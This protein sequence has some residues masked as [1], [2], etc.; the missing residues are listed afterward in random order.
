[1]IEKLAQLHPEMAL[2]ATVCVVMVIGLLRSN[3]WRAACA[4]VTGAG[5]LVAMILSLRSPVT[6]GLLPQFLPYTKTLIAAIGLL[7]LPLMGGTVDRWYEGQ[8]GRGV[9]FDPI[10]V[11]RGEFYAFYLLSFMGAM[12]CAT[13]DDLIWLFLALELT[14]LP[15]YVM[16]AMS[17]P[18]LRSQ[19]AGVKYFF[20][21]AL[22]AAT[23]LYGF[24]ML[25]GAT[26]STHLEDIAIHLRTNGLGVLSTLGLVM[27]FVGISFKIA[28]VPMHFYTPDVYQGAASPV[29]AFLAFVPKASGF[30]VL[31]QLLATVG[32]GWGEHG[33]SLPDALRIPLWVI[34]ALTMTFGNVLAM[35]QSNAK[36]MLA[37]SSIAHSGYMLV[38]LIVG[39]GKS[40]ATNGLAAAMF[41]LLCYGVMN[42]GAFAVLACLDKRNA[43]GEV[44]E[45]ETLDDL[46]GLYAARPWLAI[47]MML[48]A[49]SLLGMP[50]LLGF[51]G[52]L[53]LFTSGISAGEIGL[54]IV[55]AL[56]SA[57]A[58][59]YYL[60]L[61]R[62]AILDKRNEDFDRPALTDVFGRRLA[63]AL[64]AA[65]VLVVVIWASPLQTASDRATQLN[66]RIRQFNENVIETIGEVELTEPQT[67]AALSESK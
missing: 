53:M 41:Y 58:A 63:A 50:P 45:I 42:L 14:S 43:D 57:A 39:P 59:F 21:G 1:M 11:T 26:G 6:E 47:A 48:C 35:L 33:G 15:T 36:R 66:P 44:V 65:G 37:Y 20:L 4:W 60:R 61:V 7:V 28:A 52:K 38:G 34:A 5:L 31:I 67:V 62:A 56:N 55:M 17:T 13:A 18:R 2:F 49:L 64:S 9:A 30:I 23:F 16:V 22:S 27:A 51:W 25:Y 29:S 54:V 19:E 24:V 3:F 8:V 46:R 12:L 32:W 10:R 40:I